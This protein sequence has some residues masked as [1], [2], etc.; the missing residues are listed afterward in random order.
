M[1]EKNAKN[2][3]LIRH[4]QN[5]SIA[6]L[7]LSAIFLLMQTPL[8]GDLAGKTPYELAQELLA[9]DT[10]SEGSVT[11]DPTELALPVCVVYTS[12]YAR[13][14]LDSI[15]TLDE[16]FEQAGIFFS[17]ALGSAEAFSS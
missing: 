5:I 10:V 2:A 6:A 14:G 3:A 15:T 8:F 17:E 13:F 7:A 11:A 16:G 9:D 4:L 12:E 1:N